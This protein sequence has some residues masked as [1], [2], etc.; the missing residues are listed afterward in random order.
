MFTFL[1]PQTVLTTR[2][3]LATFEVWH[4]ALKRAVEQLHAWKQRQRL[5]P[6]ASLIISGPPHTGK[7]HLAGIV[8]WSVSNG[9]GTGRAQDPAGLFHTAQELLPRLGPARAVQVINGRWPVVVDAVGTEHLDLP[10]PDRRP[11]PGEQR[12]DRFPKL[13]RTG[14]AT[15]AAESERSECGKLGNFDLDWVESA[16]HERYRRLLQHCFIYQLPVVLATRLPVH[17]R[18]GDLVDW[19]GY[20]AWEILC[21]MAPPDSLIDLAGMPPYRGQN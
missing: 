17:G 3:T 7:T 19:I 21:R 1:I 13:G 5:E 10:P 15:S 12:K 2:L 16:R 4:P 20:Q 11:W 8:Y 14:T 9:A 18:E 6:Y